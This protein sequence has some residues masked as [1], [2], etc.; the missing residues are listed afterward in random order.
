MLSWTHITYFK[1]NKVLLVKTVSSQEDENDV[2]KVQQ[3]LSQTLCCGL[4]SEALNAW[5]VIWTSFYYPWSNAQNGT[6]QTSRKRPCIKNSEIQF[7]RISIFRIDFNCDIIKKY[8]KNN[9]KI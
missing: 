6:K 4:V 9:G 2:N 3:R 8:C 5:I 1:E 7:P